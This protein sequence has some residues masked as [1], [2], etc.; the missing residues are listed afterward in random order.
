[1]KDETMATMT[2]AEWQ[3]LAENVDT[4]SLLQAVD[5]VDTLRTHLSDGAGYRP[6]E[7]RD[8]LSQLHQPTMVVVNEGRKGTAPALFEFA[9]E[10]EDEISDMMEALT[11]IHDTITKLTALYPPSLI[12][13]SE[14][15]P[16]G[17]ETA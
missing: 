17:D 11:A 14:G 7:I 5:A 9:A 1:L 8:R 4:A 2:D 10:L 12:D 15:N 13:D 3:V 6:P 16:A